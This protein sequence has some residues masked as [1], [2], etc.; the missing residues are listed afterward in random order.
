MPSRR[1]GAAGDARFLDGLADGRGRLRLFLGGLAAAAI[2]A[3]GLDEIREIA[4]GLRIAA[5]GHP[6]PFRLAL[7]DG[8]R[9]V[10][11]VAADS[12]ARFAGKR[13]L[14]VLRVG[15]SPAQLAEILL[16]HARRHGAE[17]ALVVNRAP[18][19]AGA[20]FA[21]DLA[22]LTG[23]DLLLTVA[24]LS[25]PSGEAGSGPETH[26]FLAPDAPGKDRMTRPDPDPWRAPLAEGILYEWMKWRYL[27][28]A[29]SVVS[30]EACDI[31]PAAEGA[32]VF[33]RAEAEGI[34]ALA[35][36]RAYP[37]RVRPGAEP[38]AGDHICRM[39]DTPGGTLRWAVA[40]GMVDPDAVWR[41]RRIPGLRPAMALPFWRAMALRV[42]DA[43]GLPLAPKSSLIE[44]E[45]LV[46]LSRALGARPVRPPASAAKPAPAAAATGQRIAIVTT[47]KNEGPFILE[48]LA[49]HR[50][51][52]V[53]DFLIYTN[54][55]SDGTD[56]MLQL[57]MA[58]GLVQWRD[59]PYRAMD[60]K[61]QHAALQVAEEEAVIRNADWSVCMDVDEFINIRIG[62]GRLATLFAAME[63]ALPGANMIAMT[64]RLFGNSEIHDFDDRFVTD[65]FTRCAREVTRKPHQAWG[66][67]TLFR[68]IEIYRKLG[69]HRPRGLK[70]D[71]WE[72][73]RWLNGSGRRLPKEMFRNSWRSGVETYGYD[74]VQLN[75][76]AVRSAESFLV[77]RD[78]GR[79]N[80]VDR[81]Q[82]LHYWFRMNHNIDE[83]GS[84]RRMLPALQ[85]EWD[86]LTADPEIRAA[87]AA[88]VA[89]H[90][91][92]IAEL[93]AAPDY[94]A[95]YAE[96][97]GARMERLCRLQPHF[98][99]AVFNAGPGVIPADLDLADL[100]EDFFFTVDYDGEQQH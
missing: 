1:I 82:G 29:R 49:W 87:H 53:T 22:A 18:G 41:A 61:P 99:S 32:T 50:M 13:V 15:E 89:A 43:G 21:A 33:E 59:N 62:D 48:W 31:L 78:R 85:A 24:D 35:G 55:C 26:P 97:T 23:G 88:C 83:D 54:D 95:F 60:L 72:E 47:M 7:A 71:L 64:W 80:H 37:W 68:N 28:R 96:L 58:K 66:F 12:T 76:Y 79:V 86:R 4:G 84:I 27:V 36:R 57:L 75:H 20:A 5:A 2:A 90:R 51:I 94:A 46:A 14:L 3:P 10:L 77:K 100:P 52:G 6:G 98:G 44:D 25:L 17:A 81:D 19:D 38:R 42:A 92:R 91:G 65:Q 74:W 11:P 69:V 70:P 40:P 67:K 34:L 73:V 9:Q 39:F 8:T 63:Q 45:D 16:W 93:R 30:L 56:R